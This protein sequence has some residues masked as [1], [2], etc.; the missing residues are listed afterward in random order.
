MFSNYENY[1]DAFLSCNRGMRKNIWCKQ[2]EKC[3]FI[4]LALS[5][6]I[7]DK[8][9]NNIFGE[10]LFLRSNIR[11][12]ILRLT[13][14]KVK[15]WECV[16]VK[17]E[18]KLALALCLDSRPSMEFLEWPYRKDLENACKDVN[19]KPMLKK[20][21]KSFSEQHLLPQIFLDA[22]LDKLEWGG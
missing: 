21:C 9:L 5:A 19:I 20:Y 17:E 7:S 6:F 12:H 18:C 13:T 14:A 10:N 16:G 2:C 22:L 15:P 8:K 11:K 3:A 1:Y 4:L